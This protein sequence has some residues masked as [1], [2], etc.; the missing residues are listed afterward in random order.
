[1]IRLLRDTVTYASILTLLA[2]QN[3][4][5]NNVID[6]DNKSYITE[7]ELIQ[8]NPKND[9]R[10]EI[11]S[12][13]AIIDPSNNDIEILDSSILILNN[14]VQDIQIKSGR[15]NLNNFK[16]SIQVYNNVFISLLDGSNSYIKTNSLN[17][18]LSTTNII[19][20]NPIDINLNNTSIHSTDGIYNTELNLLKINNNVFNRTIYNSEG[21]EKYRIEIK[22]DQA[23][24]FKNKE[25]LE[26]SSKGSQVETTIKFLTFK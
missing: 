23:K 13:K 9:S 20:N 24:W 18:N 16:N 22:S 12:S 6:V 7:F 5:N 4:D 15:S 3:N 19:F 2:C 1:M 21:E 25:L 17:W 14:N 8:D 10:V 11:K 26:F